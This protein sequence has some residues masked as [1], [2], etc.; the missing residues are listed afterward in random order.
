MNRL[1]IAESHKG[2]G[3]PLVGGTFKLLDQDGLERSD[4]ELRDG[5][6]MLVC[7]S[8]LFGLRQI[9]FVCLRNIQLKKPI[10]GDR[11][12]DLLDNLIY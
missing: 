1:R 7:L 10:K 6:F 11:W 3:K 9:R 12:A 2:V 8:L 5:K 4:E